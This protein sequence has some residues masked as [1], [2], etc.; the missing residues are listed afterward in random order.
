MAPLLF[1]EIHAPPHLL[2]VHAQIRLKIAP[3]ARHSIRR[4]ILSKP[5]PKILPMRR[6]H[7]LGGKSLQHPF[8]AVTRGFSLLKMKVRSAGVFEPA[9]HRV[10]FGIWLDVFHTIAPFGG[11]QISSP[12]ACAVHDSHRFILSDAATD[13]PPA[14]GNFP[15]PRCRAFFP[16]LPVPHYSAH[17]VF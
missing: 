17:S 12:F 15:T 5:L 3:D 6:G 10:Q 4:K 11:P 7:L 2:H 13:T 9:E 16:S 1:A 14:A 8:Q